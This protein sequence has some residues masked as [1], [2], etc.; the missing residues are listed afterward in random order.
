LRLKAEEIEVINDITYS[1]VILYSRQ[2]WEEERK[3]V[4]VVKKLLSNNTIQG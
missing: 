3:R 4:S 2:K 1:G